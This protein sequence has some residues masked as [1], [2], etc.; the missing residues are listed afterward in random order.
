[1]HGLSNLGSTCW[2]NTALQTLHFSPTF[3]R[4]LSKIVE[5]VLR[6]VPKDK[7]AQTKDSSM[8]YQLLRLFEFIETGKGADRNTLEECVNSL[9][10][11]TRNVKIV[12]EPDCADEEEREVDCSDVSRL[13]DKKPHDALEDG[14]LSLFCID[15][16][17][18]PRSPDEFLYTSLLCIR[19]IALC[20]ANTH[21]LPI[22]NSDIMSSYDLLALHGNDGGNLQSQ[23]QSFFGNTNIGSYDRVC[24]YCEDRKFFWHNDLA[25]LPECLI[26]DIGSIK[27]KRVSAYPEELLFRDQDG[28]KTYKLVSAGINTGG[29]FLTEGRLDNGK[30]LT[31]D[32]REV[33]SPRPFSQNP[34]AK[35][36]IY[37]QM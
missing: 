13:F 15:H 4:A 14:V 21:V 10:S 22:E 26:V 35:F 5:A 11:T 8:S 16:E 9:K 2:F 29:H 30:W 7:L 20:S 1:V 19:K 3:R 32:D 33:S 12:I 6:D 28:I 37:E 27:T 34:N 36:L 31:V 25:K 18:N 17:R 23:L 24:P